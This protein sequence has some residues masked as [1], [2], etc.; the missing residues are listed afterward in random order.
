MGCGGAGLVGGLAATNSFRFMLHPTTKNG[1]RLPLTL[2][3]E[4]SGECSAHGCRLGADGRGDLARYGRPA[5]RAALA[6]RRGRALGAAKYEAIPFVGPLLGRPAVTG[7]PICER[8]RNHRVHAPGAQPSVKVG[9]HAPSI[10]RI[11]T[12][13]AADRAQRIGR[14]EVGESMPAATPRAVAGRFWPW[15]RLLPG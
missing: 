8:A 1:R 4:C 10:G 7:G 11:A 2:G 6:R 5:H 9:L 15:L 13:V 3:G 12:I 14:G